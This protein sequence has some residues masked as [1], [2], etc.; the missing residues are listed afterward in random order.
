MYLCFILLALS[1]LLCCLWS[2]IRAWWEARGRSQ[3]LPC[4]TTCLDL[5][6][7][8]VMTQLNNCVCSVINC[9]KIHTED[10]TTSEPY[11]N[12]HVQNWMDQKKED[13][14]CLQQHERGTA[15]RPTY[16]QSVS[17]DSGCVLDEEEGTTTNTNATNNTRPTYKTQMS[18]TSLINSFRTY[19]YQSRKGAPPPS[20]KKFGSRKASPPT[21]EGDVGSRKRWASWRRSTSRKNV[22]LSRVV[23]DPGGGGSGRPA[24]HENEQGKGFLSSKYVHSVSVDA[25]H[26]RSRGERAPPIL[27]PARKTSA[28]ILLPP[29]TT[30]NFS[31]NNSSPIVIR[32]DGGNDSPD[33]DYFTTPSKKPILPPQKLR[34]SPVRVAPG[35]PS[36]QQT[37]STALKP[38]TNT[39]V[40]EPNTLSTSN[41]SERV[42]NI[43]T[44][45]MLPPPT[46]RKGEDRDKGRLSESKAVVPTAS[47]GSQARTALGPPPKPPPPPP[48]AHI[49]HLQPLNT[50][51]TTP[52]KPS[53]AGVP[54]VSPRSK[55]VKHLASRFEGKH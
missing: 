25:T 53:D 52:E 47:Q 9:G 17:V 20:N 36:E 11:G 12:K 26:E 54:G 16:L 42:R 23:L 24:T 40:R 5:C 45:A 38:F 10:R 30:S 27:P 28:P 19:R 35:P 13:R 49:R 48:S 6:C 43:N 34:N 37:K 33:R 22:P 29:V 50:G 14:P 51:V 44:A 21:Q 55:N 31:N 8:P 46:G 39:P 18:M 1:I 4:C 32:P 41:L 3:T 2:C 15:D 7:C